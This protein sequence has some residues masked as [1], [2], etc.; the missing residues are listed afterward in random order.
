MHLLKVILE[1]VENITNIGTYAL[2]FYY[3]LFTRGQ[4]QISVSY[5]QNYLQV[6]NISNQNVNITFF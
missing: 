2:K 1:L 6:I 3:F 5:L 4:L